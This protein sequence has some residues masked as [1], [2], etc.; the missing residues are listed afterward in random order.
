MQAFAGNAQV[1][2]AHVIIACRR[3]LILKNGGYFRDDIK[4]CWLIGLWHFHIKQTAPAIWINPI[5]IE[6]VKDM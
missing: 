6:N 1:N 2:S 3:R 5:Y 4:V